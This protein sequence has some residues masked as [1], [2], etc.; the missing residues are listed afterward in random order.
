MDA[1]WNAS[2]ESYSDCPTCEGR[3]CV[4]GEAYL[5]PHCSRCFRRRITELETELNR[6]QATAEKLLPISYLLSQPEATIVGK[7]FVEV[8]FMYTATLQEK[9]PIGLYTRERKK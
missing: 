4:E 5:I 6:Y 1:K 3:G 9:E 7:T 8:L 2:S